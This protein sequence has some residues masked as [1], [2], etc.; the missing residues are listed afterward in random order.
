MCGITGFFCPRQFDKL[1]YELP[2]S[3]AVLSYRGPDDSG[4]F[5]EKSSG[6]GL[7]HRRLSVIDLSMTGHQPMYSQ[8]SRAVIVFNGEIY[9][10]KSIRSQLEQFGYHFKS[11]S[12]TEVILNAYL[13]WGTACLDHFVGMFAFA[14]WDSLKKALFLARDRLGIKPLY[15]YLNGDT[16]L[17]GSELSALMAF[18]G[19]PRTVDPD[20]FQSFLHYQYIPTP[21][22]VFR[23]TFKIEPG[24]FIIYDGKTLQK[25]QWW[26]IPGDDP[27]SVFLQPPNEQDYVN[28]LDYLLTQAVS[29]RLISD[30]PLGALLSG[31]IDSSIVV[32]IMQKISPSK[33]KTFSI[34]FQ[35]KGFNEAPWAAKIAK[36]LGTDHMELYVS[37]K[38]HWQ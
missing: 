38:T 15:Y 35:E 24:H 21:R 29:D 23:N 10:F 32:A 34:G 25:R 7:A 17:F 11:E 33:V 8:D 4:F 26:K 22:T 6:V 20:A 19:Y 9:N 12:D 5:Y 13:H 1:Q 3:A 31:G 36:H 37:P 2:Q 27:D 30:V 14:I 16:F 18:R 28:K